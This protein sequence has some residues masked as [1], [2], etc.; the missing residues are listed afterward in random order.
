MES[1]P[2]DGCERWISEKVNP[3]KESNKTYEGSLM[4]ASFQEK[5]FLTAILL[6]QQA[7]SNGQALSKIWLARS[8]L[9][10]YKPHCLQ[11]KN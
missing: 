9:Q 8:S 2:S 1:K 7:V 3:N 10:Q 4:C 6:Q 11:K 5:T